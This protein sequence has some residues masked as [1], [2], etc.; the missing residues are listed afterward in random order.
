MNINI[1]KYITYILIICTVTSIAGCHRPNADTE[2]IISSYIEEKYGFEPTVL[3]YEETIFTGWMD[4]K[5]HT[6]VYEYR[7]LDGDKSFSVL[8]DESRD[9]IYDDYIKYDAQDKLNE[10]LIDEFGRSEVNKMIINFEL[11]TFVD[12]DVVTLD[13]LQD[14]DA[15]IDVN[16]ITHGNSVEEWLDMD[17]YPMSQNFTLYVGDLKSDDMPDANRLG[18]SG[19]ISNNIPFFGDYIL[20]NYSA[21]YKE[22]AWTY[23]EYET[24]NSDGLII[25]Y[26]KSSIMS[27]EMI[28]N[29]GESRSYNVV[30]NGPGIVDI[31]TD[32]DSAK[33]WIE[34]E[35]HFSANSVSMRGQ[36]HDNNMYRVS[37]TLENSS[38]IT[39]TFD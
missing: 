5:Y 9:L 1:K 7:L 15:R 2:D 3:G 27:F 36:S 38:E 4:E 12:E 28:S 34:G 6:D 18:T 8:I 16:I 20:Y 21:I 25:T 35:S 24:I 26:D 14:S 22:G 32:S 23:G 17:I 31:L 29:D 37:I 33:L 39:V 10:I 30:L 13:D 11:F 19:S